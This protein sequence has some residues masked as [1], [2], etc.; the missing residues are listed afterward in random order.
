MLALG[1]TKELEAPEP[2]IE[3]Y[4]E[5]D[6][7]FNR[8]IESQSSFGRKASEFDH[9]LSPSAR[10]ILVITNTADTSEN[11]TM[12]MQFDQITDVTLSLVSGA[13]YIL[14]LT[15][16]AHYQDNGLSFNG[17]SE[18]VTIS[19]TTSSIELDVWTNE[20]VILLDKDSI[21]STV[22]PKFADG[23][24]KSDST[25]YGWKLFDSPLFWYV[26]VE[27]PTNGRYLIQY[28]DINEKI[29]NVEI[30]TLVP[31]TVYL[32]SEVEGGNTVLTMRYDE[33]FGNI[34]VVGL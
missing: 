25:A 20:C 15:Y 29:I 10:A 22:V 17:I 4:V 7:S 33:I 11:V 14:E 23:T 16:D 18:P 32:I 31:E 19:E 30:P 9:I 8:F 5:I 21:G 2:T 24:L 26:Y 13:E 6:L 34:I 1:C 28:S 27:A 12:N 3:D